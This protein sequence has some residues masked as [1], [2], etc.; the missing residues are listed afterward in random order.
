MVRDHQ[1]TWIGQKPAIRVAMLTHE[2]YLDREIARLLTM[3]IRNVRVF[4]RAAGLKE[5]T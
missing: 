2:G 5:N 1:E 4:R 3:P